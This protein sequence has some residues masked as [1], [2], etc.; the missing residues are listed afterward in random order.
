MELKRNE[1]IAFA[2]LSIVN[3]VFWMSIHNT[4]AI[5]NLSDP[6]TEV[7]NK[8]ESLCRMSCIPPFPSLVRLR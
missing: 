7:S 5:T 2:N 4:L 3:T 6:I 8:V 1:N